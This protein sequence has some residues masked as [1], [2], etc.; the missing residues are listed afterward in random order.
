MEK[1]VYFSRELEQ[2]IAVIP[3]LEG[4][5]IIVD[6]VSLIETKE[7]SYHLPDFPF[8]WVFFFSSNAVE[9]FFTQKPSLSKHIRF[10]AVGIATATALEKFQEVSFVGNGNNTTAISE[11]FLILLGSKSV[12]VPQS[13]ISINPLSNKLD[14]NRCL[15]L[16][17]YRT[18]LLPRK[19]MPA[20]VMVFSS[21][22]N[23]QSYFLMNLWPEKARAIS[24]GPA[25][26]RALREYGV[27]PWVQLRNIEPEEI[28]RAIIGVLCS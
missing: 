11:E 20:E 28:G 13:D 4:Q 27:E 18:A 25:T 8:D 23:V 14:K 17:C 24:F 22:S 26:T 3:F 7:V 16:V 9:Y 10:A 19:V 5:N 1:R 12:L 2:V 15:D 6:A 21:P